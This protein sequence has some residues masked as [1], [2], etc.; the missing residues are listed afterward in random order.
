MISTLGACP[1]ENAQLLFNNVD[2]SNWTKRGGEPAEWKVEDGVL[3]VVPG[4][5]DIMT[6]SRF[7]DF[8]LHLE[9]RCPDM[10]EATAQ[11]KGNSGV[12][13]QGRYEI[14]VLDS[15]GWA[16]PGKADCGA[17]YNQFAPLENACAPA[18][19]WQTYDIIFR[20]P[21]CNESNAVVEAARL[22]VLL[23]GIVI[24]NNV[25]LAGVTGAPLDEKVEEPGPILLQDHSDLVCYRNIWITP[26]AE[27]GSDTYEPH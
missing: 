16:S 5:K 11:K 14:Q 13:L 23:N 15:S 27:K 9:F 1:P 8:F 25:Q 4:K 3:H 10:P 18:M 7:R 6:K 17:V 21:R 26:L 22:T 2:V 19:Q 24:Q 12:F 20:A